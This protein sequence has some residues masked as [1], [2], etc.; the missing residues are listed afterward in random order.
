MSADLP[1]QLQIKELELN[2]LFD[3]IRA[4]NNNSSEDDL[5][6]IYK[7]TLR[8]NPSVR[9]L[10]LF[11]KDDS[12]WL[13]KAGF[14]TEHDYSQLAVPDSLPE[15]LTQ[16]DSQSDLLKG[17]PFFDEFDL[18]L[19]IKHKNNVLGMAF[20]SHKEKVEDEVLDLPFITALSHIIIVAVE[21]KKFARREIQQEALRRQ[22]SIAKD[23]QTLLFPKSL[24]YDE[25]QEVMASYKP[26]HSV[27]GDYY[28]FIEIDKDTFMMCIADVSGK[29]VPAAILMSNFQAALRILLRR[30]QDLEEVVRELNHLIMEN[31][32]GENF[33][34]AFF[35]LYSFKE[36]RL[37]YINAGHNPP[38]LFESRTK[39]TPLKTGTTIL[40]AFDELPFLNAEKIEGIKDFLLFA[41][42]DGF[43]ETYN[44][45]GEEFGEEL[46]AD[47][48]SE[49]F[50]SDQ[51]QLHE[52]LIT[53]LNT[54]KGKNAFIDDIT[55][56]SC[57][58][59]DLL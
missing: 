24:P 25:R 33:I 41:F 35:V 1:A 9:K 20:L 38:F 54:F 19:P 3:T 12:D 37:T 10:C 23:V 16:P 58:I 47:F 40:G 11:V 39:M 30:T 49:N 26:H 31:S 34:T 56:L 51:R 14:G 46:M 15:K 8:S 42:T 5:Y 55:L 45:K 13:F 27:G 48:I 36:N 50:D 22:I 44:E 32:G 29:G 28:D 17:I 53:Y 18:L 4:I 59:R 43:I 57:R 6:L 21:N 2:A 7:F 52:M